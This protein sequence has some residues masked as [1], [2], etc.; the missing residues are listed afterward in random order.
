MCSASQA[1]FSLL[2]LAQEQRPICPMTASCK[3]TRPF[4]YCLSPLE[5]CALRLDEH[6]DNSVPKEEEG[7]DKLVSA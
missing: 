5:P 6:L 4:C 2:P 3:G 1:R 7:D